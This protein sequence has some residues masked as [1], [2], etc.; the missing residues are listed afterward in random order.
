MQ[1]WKIP[2][3][4]IKKYVK[5]FNNQQ[6]KINTHYWTLDCKNKNHIESMR[7]IYTPICLAVKLTKVEM[8][9][10]NLKELMNSPSF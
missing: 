9:H 3:E 5:K 4:Y 8:L 7:A 2:L 10:I 1:N 6:Y